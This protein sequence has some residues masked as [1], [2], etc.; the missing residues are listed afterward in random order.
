M[1][2]YE[3]A[4]KVLSKRNDLKTLQIAAKLAKKSEN[5]D[6]LDAIMLQCKSID[7][8]QTEVVNLPSRINAIMFENQNEFSTSSPLT[9]HTDDKGNN[10]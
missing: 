10:I 3:E 7:E 1:K 2:K 6:L 8:N 5:K 4:A 9:E